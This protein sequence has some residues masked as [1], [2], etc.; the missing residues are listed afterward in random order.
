[1]IPCRMLVWTAGVRPHPATSRLGLPLDPNGRIVVDRTLRVPGRTD[2]WAIGDAAAVPDPAAKYRRPCPPTCQHAIRQGRLVARNV[3]AELG[4]GRVRPFRYKTKGVFVDMGQQQAVATTMGIKWR[5]KL[6]WWL[7]RTYHL[8]MV[9][10]FKRRA[11]LLVD[12]NVQL[13]F[14]R[15]SSELGR[16][17][18]P[19]PLVDQTSGGVPVEAPAHDGGAHATGR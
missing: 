4:S 9:P 10:G 16:L 3:A 8:G 14:G 11:R 19:G 17:G 12:W 18:H 2:V 15:D 1:V 5:G 7:A 13:F 6:A